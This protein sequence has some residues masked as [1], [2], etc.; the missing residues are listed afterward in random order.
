VGILRGTASAPGLLDVSLRY[1]RLL[2]CR[3]EVRSLRELNSHA[4]LAEI[5][6]IG[7]LNLT[8]FFYL[9]AGKKTSRLSWVIL[10]L[11][12]D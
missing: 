1:S 8:G 12:N 11:T 10:V 9:Y 3:A 4:G 7:V 5:M 2:L 6:K